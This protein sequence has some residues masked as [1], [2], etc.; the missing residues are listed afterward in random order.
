MAKII[1][2]EV[3]GKNGI[4]V[5]EVGE[6][7][8]FTKRVIGAIHDNSYEFEDS[9]LLTYEIVDTAGKTIARFENGTYSVW[10]EEE[11]NDG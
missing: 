9:I 2:L 7:E 6:K 10:Y 11:R 1:R 5:Y 8:Y 4:G 3:H